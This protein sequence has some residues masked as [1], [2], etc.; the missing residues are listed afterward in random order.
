MDLKKETCNPEF[1]NRT[2]IPLDPC[3]HTAH[4]LLVEHTVEE[5]FCY[6]IGCLGII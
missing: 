1:V 6:V 4:G 3:G 2:M 5:S